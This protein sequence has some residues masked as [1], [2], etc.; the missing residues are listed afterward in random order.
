MVA[1]QKSDYMDDQVPHVDV[2][3]VLRESE[4][5]AGYC[6]TAS[7]GISSS[8]ENAAEAINSAQLMGALRDQPAAT[9]SAGDQY[10]TQLLDRSAESPGNYDCRQQ[11]EAS[12]AGDVVDDL[13]PPLKRLNCAV[14]RST[15]KE[16]HQLDDIK[17][18]G[19]EE[20]EE[21]GSCVTPTAR[22]QRIPREI[23]VCPP[24]PKKRK[25]AARYY[26]QRRPFYFH[27]LSYDQA[28]INSMNTSVFLPFSD[29]YICDADQFPGAFLAVNPQ[30]L[31]T[32]PEPIKPLSKST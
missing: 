29:V 19:E 27:E 2:S 26:K 20:E 3:C 7:S 15:A 23:L 14:S 12:A 6:P 32:L 13:Y 5:T 10:I 1:S 17:Q 31:H 11:V 24:A 16:S 9:A 28:I 8:R 25:A 21:E 22:E 18:E 30:D 4:Q